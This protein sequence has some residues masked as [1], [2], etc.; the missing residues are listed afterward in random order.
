M[1]RRIDLSQEYE[2]Y[3]FK[4]GIKLV[5]RED[6][7]KFTNNPF[8]HHTGYTLASM[9]ALPIPIYFLNAS[10]EGQEVNE[11]VLIQCGIDSKKDAYGKSIKHFATQETAIRALYNTK[12]VIEAARP[13]FFDEDVIYTDRGIIQSLAVKV[14]WYGEDN[15]IIGIVG[16]SMTLGQQSLAESLSKIQ[17]LNILGCSANSASNELTKVYLS[18][19]EKECLQLY[20]QGKTAKQCAKILNISYRTFENYIQNIKSKLNV[21][22]KSELILLANQYD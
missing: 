18:Q 16:Y 1:K 20:T 10:G 22:S 14:P 12:Q 8:Y 7:A 5:K 21:T 13:Q 6:H 2:V 15:Q 17:S 11:A 4:Q 19:R 3:R 9:Q